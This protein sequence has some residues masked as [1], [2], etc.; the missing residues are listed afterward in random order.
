VEL[1][2]RAAILDVLG[3]SL[4]DGLSGRIEEVLSV[5]A[6]TIV[7]F[8]PMPLTRRAGRWITVFAPWCSV[9]EPTGLSAR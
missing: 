3:R 1:P 7:A 9:S 6:R 4:K 2:G 8:R 5:G